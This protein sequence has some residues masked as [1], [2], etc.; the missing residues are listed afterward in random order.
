LIARGLAAST[1][2]RF[3]SAPPA[4][5]WGKGASQRRMTQQEHSPWP[6]WD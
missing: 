1:D 5:H 4:P 2:R 3:T 6:A